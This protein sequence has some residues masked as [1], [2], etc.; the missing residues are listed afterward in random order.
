METSV[1]P[2]ALYG[3]SNVTGFSGKFCATADVM[4]AIARINKNSG[5]FMTAPRTVLK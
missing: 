4:H 3:T 2:P 1:E 5:R